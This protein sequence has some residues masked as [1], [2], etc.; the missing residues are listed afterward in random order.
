MTTQLQTMPDGP[1]KQ[2]MVILD[3]KIE[4]MRSLLPVRY[5]AQAERFVK[6][7][8]VH[9]MRKKELA[10]CTPGSF[11]QC[12]MQAG[13][14][15]LAIDGRLAH[16]VPMKGEAVLM[17]DY[18]GAIAVARRAGL[19]KDAWARL[20]YQVEVDSGAFKLWEDDDGAHI[21]HEISVVS[22]RGAIV[23]AY[24]RV[25]FPDGKSRFEWMT[26]D[27]LNEVR[28][29]SKAFQSKSGPWTT[30]VGDGEMRKKTVLH[31]ALK[32]YQDDP[33]I[34]MLAAIEEADTDLSLA[35]PLPALDKPAP[36]SDDP[37][38]GANQAAVAGEPVVLDD[39]EVGMQYPDEGAP[40]A[41][42]DDP[43]ALEAE[44]KMSELTAALDAVKT[45]ADL[46]RVRKQIDADI[47][48][49][50][51]SAA[52]AFRERAGSI[53]KRL[54]LAKGQRGTAARV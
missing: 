17:V 9:F 15:G 19:I 51:L 39:G 41:P 8:I 48:L 20:V 23:G 30:L 1:A 28:K 14:L 12:V 49:I 29:L 47:E 3:G 25:V 50:G 27:E 2:M 43:M 7:A 40:F 11:I 5:Q 53:G 6:R 52:Q 21:R 38:M 36:E 42:A 4:T 24:A 45:P 16:A 35:E 10:Q 44:S 18:K 34:S 46:D 32:G 54:T 13:E 37:L 33:T 26:N 31:R 22:Q